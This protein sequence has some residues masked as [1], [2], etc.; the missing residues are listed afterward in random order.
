MHPAKPTPH[1]PIQ[2]ISQKLQQFKADFFKILK[3]NVILIVKHFRIISACKCK[4][5]VYAHVPLTTVVQACSTLP[6]LAK[7]KQLSES[8][9]YRF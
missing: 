6:H 3:P 5:Y 2:K 4:F 9:I 7:I 1:L 8:N